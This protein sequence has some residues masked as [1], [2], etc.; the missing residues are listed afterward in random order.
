MRFENSIQKMQ[1]HRLK[2]LVVSACT[3]LFGIIFGWVLFPSILKFMI[4]KVC[5]FVRVQFKSINMLKFAIFRFVFLLQQVTLKEGTDIRDLWSK[6]PFPLHFYIYVFN[7]TNP[8]EVAT[9]G[10]PRLQEIGPFVF[11]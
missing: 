6:T 1:V 8:E 10:K 5:M 4:S 11:E 3:L 9:G 2:L 7:V